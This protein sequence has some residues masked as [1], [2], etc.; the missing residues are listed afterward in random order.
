MFKPC[1]T[2]LLCWVTLCAA[3]PVDQDKR[4]A[5]ERDTLQNCMCRKRFPTSL[6]VEEPAEG[7]KEKKKESYNWDKC[8]EAEGYLSRRCGVM[9]YYF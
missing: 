4:C 2:V 3:P 9:R 5:K 6:A 8:R 7:C 1:I